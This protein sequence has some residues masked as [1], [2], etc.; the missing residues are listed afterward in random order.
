MLLCIALAVLLD[1]GHPSL[2]RLGIKYCDNDHG[3]SASYRDLWEIGRF[4]IDAASACPNTTSRSLS[5]RNK[6]FS[7]GGNWNP[8]CCRAAYGGGRDVFRGG[9]AKCIVWVEG[10]VR[11]GRGHFWG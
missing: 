7:A 5:F 10:G 3:R 11:P 9:M 8:L 1:L 2:V 4:C 6:F